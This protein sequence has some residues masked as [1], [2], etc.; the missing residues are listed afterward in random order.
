MI[1]FLYTAILTHIN[2]VLIMID[3]FLAIIIS[4]STTVIADAA[5]ELSM[6]AYREYQKLRD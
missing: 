2:T 3:Y 5:I 4:D 6:R 1:P